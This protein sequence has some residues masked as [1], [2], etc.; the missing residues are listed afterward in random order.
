MTTQT[1]SSKPR[2]TIRFS[3]TLSLVRAIA[4]SCSITIGMGV[5][6]LVGLFVQQGGTQ[7]PQAYLLAMVL[8]LP[9]VLTYAERATITPGAGGIFGLIRTGGSTW[10]TYAGGWLL[11]GGHLALIALLGWGASLYLNISLERLLGVSIDLR[12]IAPAMIVGVALNDVIGT[13]GSWRLRTMI[14]Y[15]SLVFLVVI[16]AR[17]WFIADGAPTVA[18]TADGVDD[19]FHVLALMS[20]G[21]WGLQFALDSRDDMR[22]PE[23]NVPPSLLVPVLLAG[24]LGALIVATELRSVGLQSDTM[25]PLATL[26]IYTSF[27]GEALFEV[28]YVSLG[29]FVSLAALDR[30]MVTLLRLMGAMVRDG[31][32]PE[33]ILKI[34]PSLGTPLFA[35]RLLA[36]GSALVAVLAPKPLLVG[37]VALSLLWTTALFNAFAVSKAGAP[38]PPER[39]FKLP[40]HPLLPVTATIISLALSFAL[41]IPVLLLGAVWL[42]LGA[43]FYVG[44]ARQSGIQVRRRD[45]MVGDVAPAQRKLSYTVLVGIANPETAPDLIRAGAALSRSRQGRMLVLRVVSFPD[46]VPQ[47]LQR[48]AAQEQLQDLSQIIQQMSIHHEPVEM[49]V[50]LARN[51]IDGILATAQEER[52]D[53]I[54]L[55]WEGEIYQHTFDL[56]PLIDPVVRAAACNVVVVRGHLPDRPQSILVPTAGSPNTLAAM[57]LAQDIVDN[58][59]GRVVA[60]NLVQEVFSPTTMDEAE[61]RLRKMVVGLGGIPP[62]E[63]L[64]RETDDVKDGII[65]EAQQFDLLMLGASR[66]GALDQTIFGGLPVEVAR[67]APGPALLVKRYEGARHFWARRAWE[68]ISAPFPK[69][70]QSERE[71]IYFQMRRAGHPSIDFFI[72]IALSAMI[73]TLGLLLS[74]PAVIIGAMLVAPLMSP[75]LAIAMSMVQGDLRLL[76]LSANATALGIILA[77]SV[78]IMVTLVVTTQI[79]T[80]EILARTRPNLLDLLV[81]LASGAAGGYAMGRKEVA[82]AL[83]GVAISAA[84][85]PPLGVIGYGTATG[86]LYIAGG[87]LLLF[88]TNLVAIIFA[89]A[90][91]FLLLGFRPTQAR[92]RQVVQLKFLL[93]LLALLLI[94]IPLAIF[95]VDGVGQVA[96]QN[97]VEN[98]LNTEVESREARIT[99]VIVERQGTGF[100]VHATIYAIDEMSSDDLTTL[101]EELSSAMNAPVT[102]RA[103]V[104]R[105]MV[106]PERGEALLPEPPP[107]P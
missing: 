37:F 73:A 96:R 98:V 10:R 89:A 88:T 66:G 15:G 79:N 78:S 40:F 80:S 33:R 21:M 52:A 35:L 51:P 9:A 91:I 61:D 53:L 39:P 27:R 34:T 68:T 2:F 67:D 14:V 4:M 26:A 58:D 62:V 32:L 24:S 16:A 45:S 97:Q 83:P 11:L 48:Q 56:G 7:T 90:V 72:L 20:A 8:W 31:F 29:L 85:V 25:T 77:V 55:G 75:I 28:I 30:A 86:Q 76:R 65:H 93:S 106:L 23:R 60:L 87:S 84:L 99:D 50:R 81:A 47:H 18:P 103:T 82:A 57:K 71:D 43:L 1:S 41:P 6:I 105:A 69:L 74:S 22:D 92:M 19:L 95:S 104:L 12:W 3:R 70:T 42:L 64:V 5:L 36:I 44:Y 107:T 63:P 38:L 102:L 49:L 17:S 101:Q 54:V 100:I 13:Q 46:Q 94:S 59:R